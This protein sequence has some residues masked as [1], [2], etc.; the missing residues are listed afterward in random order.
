MRKILWISTAVP[1]DSVSH[2]GGK[3]HNYYIKY[4]KKSGLFDIHLVSLAEAYEADK[5]DLDRYGI[6]SDICV[7]GGNFIKNILRMMF[8]MN[9]MFN[10]KHR[11]C[12]TILSYQFLALKK[13]V[14][15][16]AEYNKPD[17]VIMQWT[18]A[19]FLLPYVRELFPEAKTIIIE[20]DVS[21]LGYQRKYLKEKNK[22]KRRQKRYRYEQL[23]KSE[24]ALLANSDL[25]VVNN[26]K[27]KQ[28]IVDNGIEEHNI[29]VAAPYYDDYSGI[30]RKPGSNILFYGN[31]NREENHS[32][33]IWFAREVMPYLQNESIEYNVVGNNPRAEWKDIA[34]KRIHVRG[35]VEDVT[36]YFESCLCM[37][38]PLELGA[39]IK[40]KVLEGLS[41]GIPVLTNEVGIEG[42]SAQ[43][44]REYIHC[45][46]SDDYIDSIKDL[47]D[48][49]EK[50]QQIGENAREYMLHNY[51]IDNKLDG[52]IHLLKEMTGD[53]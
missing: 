16:Y 47:L 18:G 22:L 14:R 50:V 10:Y 21:F 4:L 33:A 41:A 42:I 39:G 12:Q 38:A 43:K 9:S 52:L 5:I 28:L 24:L 49:P 35:Y 6:D 34:N 51:N 2:A 3:T 25:V 23:K 44:D 13:R 15:K 32:A 20:E 29:Y 48:H 1:Y 45:A 26:E 11:L 31:M 7:V 30:E 40:V 37:V 27:D 17:Y 46:T 8:N 19:A 53:V 36:P